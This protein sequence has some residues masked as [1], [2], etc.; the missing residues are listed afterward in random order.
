VAN[1]NEDVLNAPIID[2]LGGNILPDNGKLQNIK[3]YTAKEF[4]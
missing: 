1:N 3:K 4:F 2:T